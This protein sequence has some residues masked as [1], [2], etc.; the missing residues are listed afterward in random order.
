MKIF[1]SISTIN[2]RLLKSG[3]DAIE[4]YSEINDDV[5]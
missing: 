3:V 2:Q 5:N 1:L 4:I